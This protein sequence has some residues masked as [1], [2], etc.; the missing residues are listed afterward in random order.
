MKKETMSFSKPQIVLVGLL[1]VASFLIGKL[2][3][4]VQY[5]KKGATSAGTGQPAAVSKYKSF[6]DAMTAL[7]KSV[8]IDSKKL[9]ACVNSG[10]KKEVVDKEAQEAQAAGVNGTPAFFIN[11]RLLGG[12]FPFESFKE[13]ID[14]ELAGTATDNVEDYSETLQKAAASGAFDPKPK[15]ITVGKAHTLGKG[16]SPIVI[17][18]Y[19]DFQC[20]YCEAVYPTVK[21]V[22]QE[23]GDKVMFTYKHLPLISIHPH[24]QKTAEAAECAADQG[25][26]WEFH[27]ALFESQKDWT[28]I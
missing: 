2:Y 8:K 18:E 16:G 26:F 27:D 9:V 12:A 23:Y 17:V 1:L 7:A 3:T 21:Q 5:L 22:L 14:K 6:D 11:G 20:P 28:S 10:E 15:N 19:S 25:K 13:V 24:A 4:E